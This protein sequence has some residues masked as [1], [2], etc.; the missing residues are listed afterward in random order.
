[1]KLTLALAQ[2][3]TKLGDVDANLEK[4]LALAKEAGKN[5]AE[6]II[7]PEL[8]LTG[9]VLQDIAATV[10]NALMK[11]L[12]DGTHTPDIYRKEISKQKLGTKEFAE[13]VGIDRN[14]TPTPASRYA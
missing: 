10:H 13:A 3:N 4:H 6:L 2:I 5:G 12:E 14:S 11:T 8:S 1:M 7:F 9:Y